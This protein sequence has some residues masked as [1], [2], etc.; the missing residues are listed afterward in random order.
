L[1]RNSIRNFG[2]P[3]FDF[4]RDLYLPEKEFFGFQAN[5]FD[6]FHEE[7]KFFESSPLIIHSPQ[8]CIHIYRASSKCHCQ[9]SSVAAYPAS[10]GSLHRPKLSPLAGS[11]SWSSALLQAVS[12]ENAYRFAGP[13]LNAGLLA[14]QPF[15]GCRR[16]SR[17][18]RSFYR[19]NHARQGSDLSP[20]LK[21]FGRRSRRVA[22]VLHLAHFSS[23]MPAHLQAYRIPGTQ[24]APPVLQTCRMQSHIWR[25][26]GSI[27]SHCI[28][29]RQNASGKGCPSLG[30]SP[31]LFWRSARTSLVGNGCS[32]KLTNGT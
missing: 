30:I 20:Q 16:G 23:K 31:C 1:I 6:A 13:S 8:R 32:E 11:R 10:L 2:L 3:V 27:S 21:A 7:R 5:F 22:L 9:Y 19:K 18:R 28:K 25:T 26:S 12:V 29:T 24:S 17:F 14:S 15:L 4:A